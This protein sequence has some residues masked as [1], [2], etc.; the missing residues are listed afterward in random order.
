MINVDYVNG[1]VSLDTL[2]IMKDY[3]SFNESCKQE[4]NEMFAKFEMLEDRVTLESAIMDTVPEQMMMVYESEKKNL[5]A[6]IGEMIIK[7]FDKFIKTIEGFIDKIKFNILNK[8]T[9]LQKVDILLKKHPEL[10]NEEIAEI[11]KAFVDGSLTLNDVKS[12]K[13]LDK[14][15]D[16]IVKMVKKKDID[17]KSIKGRWE[18]IKAN[19]EKDEKSWKIVKVGSA[20]TVAVGAALALRKLI[21]EWKK[22][23][24]DGHELKKKANAEKAEIL[25]EL[26]KSTAVNDTM[27]KWQILLEIWRYKN[28]KYTEVYGGIYNGLDKVAK[29]LARFL[30]KFDKKG[31]TVEAFKKNLETIAF[32]E[33]EK[34]EKEYQDSIKKAEDEAYARKEAE[35]KHSQ[36]KSI[37][38]ADRTMADTYSKAE[39]NLKHYERNKGRYSTKSEDD[40]TT[41]AEANLKHYENNEKRYNT[42]TKSEQK[43]RDS[44]KPHQGD[45]DNGS[46]SYH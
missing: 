39:A 17:P 6:R 5:F 3:E 27:G 30:D 36:N 1:S 12:L 35:L 24:E 29:G 43:A 19:F 42:K 7:I 44:V 21:P 4:I 13:E 23:A 26:K 22:H 28:E 37:E 38:Y 9:D 2:D 40:A 15:F 14:A 10:K 20:T 16:E 8:K 33:N 11:Q 32:K 25:E 41:K 45:H 31:S 18:K 34:K 46:K